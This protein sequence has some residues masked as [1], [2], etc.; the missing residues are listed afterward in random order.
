MTHVCRQGVQN[1][2][3]LRGALIS[4]IEQKVLKMH[5]S[6]KSKYSAGVIINLCSVDTDNIMSFNWNSNHELWASPAIIVISL[7]WL[8]SFLGTAALAGCGIMFLSV[9]LS[10]G[11]LIVEI[12]SFT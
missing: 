8:V 11:L 6:V 7:V 9:L 1:A 2:L 12:H 3:A 5:H 4:L 10:A